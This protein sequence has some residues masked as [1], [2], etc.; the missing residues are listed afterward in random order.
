MINVKIWNERG[1]PVCCKHKVVMSPEYIYNPVT[2]KGYF[3]FYK[4]PKCEYI[5]KHMNSHPVR[6]ERD[7]VILRE[8]PE[9]QKRIHRY[10]MSDYKSLDWETMNFHLG[11]Y[12]KKDKVLRMLM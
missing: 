4:C 5:K 9:I 3:N 8:I 12:L 7:E 6:L 10:M 1:E 2:A 11:R